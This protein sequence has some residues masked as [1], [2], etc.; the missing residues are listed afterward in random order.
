MLVVPLK[1]QKG[2]SCRRI[3]VAGQI[4]AGTTYIELDDVHVP[5]ENLIGKEGEGMRYI[6]NN[7]NHERMFISVGTTRQARVAL[8]SAFE[9]CMKREAFGKVQLKL[10]PPFPV[11]I[12]IFFFFPKGEEAN[13]A[14]NLNQTLMD[15][16]VVRHRLAKCAAMLE[17]Q[18]TWVE[19]F[20][21]QLT[22]LSK[23]DADRELGGLTALCKAN[24]GIVIDECARCAV[25]LFGGNGF[26]RTGQG[27]IAESKSTSV[28]DL[29]LH[30]LQKVNYY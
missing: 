1:G 20:A 27:E 25:L 18:Q 23:K 13:R 15:Q 10:S 28:K 12:F 16:P 14:Y 24:A 2:V 5:K 9:Y 19:S 22:K 3:K 4:S 21:Y 26:T 6:M 7:F 17:A 30:R 29:V 11:F 8:S